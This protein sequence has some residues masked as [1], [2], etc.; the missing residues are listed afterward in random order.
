MTAI[1]RIQVETILVRRTKELLE[2]VGLSAA[3]DL[4]T[5]D[6]LNEPMRVALADLEIAATDVLAVSDTDLAGVADSDHNALFDLCE[7]G[8]LM[9]IANKMTEVNERRG[10]ISDSFSDLP[11]RVAERI[12]V[13][14]ETISNKYGIGGDSSLNIGVIDLSISATLPS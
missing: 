5:N 2:H 11:E 7:L 13:L 14:A 9:I 1:T 8:M 12:K 6:D 3:H 4:G 10:P